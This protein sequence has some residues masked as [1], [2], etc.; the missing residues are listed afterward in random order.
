MLNVKHFVAGT[1]R[2]ALVFLDNEIKEWIRENKVTEV[3]EIR[4]TFG[5]APTG[6][7]GATE[8]VLFVSI[9]YETPN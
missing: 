6:M 2:N 5:Q 8:N 1:T 3:K 9:W 7:S 4:E